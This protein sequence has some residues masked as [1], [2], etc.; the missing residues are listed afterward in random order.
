M[1]ELYCDALLKVP[2]PS[3]GL[4]AG[5]RG[6]LVRMQHPYLCRQDDELKAQYQAEF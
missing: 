2:L 1:R 3:N 4:T 6:V 5:A